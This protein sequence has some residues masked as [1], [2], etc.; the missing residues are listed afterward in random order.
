M[1]V[2]TAVC[3]VSNVPGDA[4]GIKVDCVALS[5][6]H[7]SSISVR[8]CSVLG[9][10]MARNVL[11]AG[12]S[13]DLNV[14]A[15]N[16]KSGVIA[17]VSFETRSMYSNGCSAGFHFRDLIFIIASCVDLISENCLLKRVIISS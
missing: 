3:I 12:G 1:A 4:A 9:L 13:P 16:S 17:L 14:S 10:A 7:L 6:S 8:S 15:L 11:A 5:R 2:I